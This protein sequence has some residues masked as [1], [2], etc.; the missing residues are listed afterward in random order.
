M[1]NK[2]IIILSINILAVIILIGTAFNSVV[3]ASSS[4][5][6][7]SNKIKDYSSCSTCSSGC[8]TN[9]S[10]AVEFVVKYSWEH[11]PPFPKIKWFHAYPITKFVSDITLWTVEFTVE[12]QNGF[13]ETCYQPMFVIADVVVEATQ[14]ALKEVMKMIHEILFIFYPAILAIAFMK[15]VIYYLKQLC[16]GTTPPDQNIS[17]QFI[18]SPRF[19]PMKFALQKINQFIK[20]HSLLFHNEILFEM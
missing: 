14:Y 16:N 10:E 18:T 2:K 13:K 19:S 8:C 12:L 7:L 9:C 1:F 15:A 4:S 6:Q 17:D 3:V 11:M 20:N 5:Y